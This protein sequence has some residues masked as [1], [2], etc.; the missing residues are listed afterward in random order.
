M[1]L[2]QWNEL[3]SWMAPITAL[4]LW[5]ISVICF[6]FGLS[7]KDPIMVAGYDLTLYIAFAIAMCNTFI[8][9]IGNGNTEKDES[10]VFTWI[11]R[12]SYLLGIASNSNALLQMI[13][14]SSPIL[15]WSVALSLGAI[16]EIAPEKLIMIWLKSIRPNPSYSRNQ[17][18]NNAFVPQHGKTVPTNIPTF[19]QQTTQHQSKGNGTDRRKMLEAEQQKKA[20]PTYHP[21]G[22]DESELPKWARAE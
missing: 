21:V 7:F 3:K 18:N 15:E 14:I 22:M 19:R 9:L 12:A 6:V 5:V 16:I 10:G 13:G 11:W 8:Q 20:A 17:G 2:K 1:T 4:I